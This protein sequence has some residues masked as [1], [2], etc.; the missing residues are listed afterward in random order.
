MATQPVVEG[1]MYLDPSVA[2]NPIRDRIRQ[3]LSHR[4]RF[5]PVWNSNL[6]WAGGQHWNVWDRDTRTL[7]R[8]EDVDPRYR[9]RELYSVDLITQYRS[10]ILGELGSDDARPQL[11][12]AQDSPAAEAFQ[13]ELNRAVG[14]AWDH[15]IRADEAIAEVDRLTI[16][17]GTAGMRCRFDPTQGPVIGEAPYVDGKPVM[18]DQAMQLMQGFGGGPVPGV[19]MQ[20][21]QSGRI[22]W[23][24]LSSFNILPPPGITHETWFPW[25]AVVRPTYIGDVFAEFG[26][27][28]E[29]LLEDKNIA[30]T[31]GQ[32]QQSGQGGAGYTLGEGRTARLRDHVWLYTYYERSTKKYPQGRVLHFAGKELKFLREENSLPY[33]KL[34]HDGQPI[35]YHSG[36]TYFHYWRVTGRF[37]S[38]SLVENLKEANRAY[39]KRRTQV[40]EMIDRGL[41]AVFVREGSEALKKTDTPLEIIALGTTEVRPD[42]FQGIGP[43]PWMREEI[44]QIMTDMEQASGIRAPA[45]GEN[46]SNVIT[47]GQLSLLREADMVKR[48]PTMIGRKHAIAR[49]IESTVYD[50]RTYWGTEKH[51]ALA[52]ETDRVEA[53]QFNATK[54]PPF[55]I[56]KIAKGESK[57][58]S[59]GAEL[60]KIE[61]LWNAAVASGAVELDPFNW[62]EWYYNSLE[63]G[64]A[65]E[66]PSEGLDAQ[67][68]KAE[69]ENHMM[70]EGTP[71]PVAYYDDIE[72]HLPKHREAQMEAEMAQEMNVWTLLEKHIQEHLEAQRLNMEATMEES[73]IEP[74]E[75]GEEVAEE[76]TA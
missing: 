30:S 61:Q 65:L 15:E 7:R 24:P 20:P 29:G 68:E 34:D 74:T 66:L 1:G 42:F 44:E 45:L 17:L 4:E 3:A 6:A 26:D 37:W 25:E 19:E 53:T 16:D 10:T 59:Q 48:Q 47:L 9:R 2:L 60:T 72:A 36:I 67:V 54:I 23:E 73:R 40:N 56:V 8:I 5:E 18:G 38:R 57:P 69:I 13:T 58:R 43:G 28:A 70:W 31:M 55:F 21:V 76:E 46:P 35:E 39:D 52:G 71:V 51:I 22:I 50:I 41:P 27:A 12:L 62:L 75:E 32:V 33:A 14:Y 11:L 63:G 64:K 49:L